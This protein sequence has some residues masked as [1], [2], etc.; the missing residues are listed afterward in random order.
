M[1]R[2]DGLKW[3]GM[4]SAIVLPKPYA[5]LCSFVAIRSLKIIKEIGNAGS[6]STP[7]RKKT[8]VPALLWHSVGDVS[9]EFWSSSFFMLGLRGSAPGTSSGSC[10]TASRSSL[11]GDGLRFDL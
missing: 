10:C 7:E 9:Q 2:K 8:A 5:A 4:H 6:S 3:L 1:M 11:R